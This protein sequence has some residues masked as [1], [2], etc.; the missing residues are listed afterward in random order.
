MGAYKYPKHSESHLLAIGTAKLNDLALRQRSHGSHASISLV[1]L[2]YVS[3]KTALASR[4]TSAHK[5]LYLVGFMGAGKTT[6]GRRLAK[7][8]GWKFLDLD[9]EIEHR[10]GRTVAN[11]FKEDGERHF[12]SLEHSCLKELASV[13]KA[14]IAMG[15]GAF[16]DPENRELAESTG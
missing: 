5:R 13:P 14:V 12:R 16:V 2:G 7:K 3:W 6:V 9:E 8:L 10:E 1:Q 15:G 4:M 11:I